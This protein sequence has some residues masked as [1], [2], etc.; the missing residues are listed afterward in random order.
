MSVSDKVGNLNKKGLVLC[1]NLQV[2]F[3]N[4]V[5][6]PFKPSSG[7]VLCAINPIG[8]VKRRNNV[9]IARW[10]AGQNANKGRNF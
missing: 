10:F 8:Y 9:I 6:R 3:L 7:Y 1:S 4:F 2:S 5:I